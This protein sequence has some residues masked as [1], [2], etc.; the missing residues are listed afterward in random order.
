MDKKEKLF[1]E[2]ENSYE[3]SKSDD[4][5][6]EHKYNGDE[7]VIENSYDDDEVKDDMD[8]LYEVHN[9]DIDRKKE[10]KKKRKLLSI[11]GEIL[12]YV[13]LI[14]VCAIIIPNYVI[15]RTI[16]DGPSMENTLHDGEN[17]LVEKFLYKAKGLERFD[18]VVFYPYGRE[19]TD[20]YVKRV[21]GLPGET[22]QIIGSDI[23][24][25]G[26]LLEENY[27]KDK[28]TNPGIAKKPI[29]LSE[30]EIFVL[31]DNREVSLDSRYEQVGPVPLEYV[32]G[33]VILRIYPFNKFGTID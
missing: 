17:V 21:I 3:N 22:V 12:F 15:Q 5:A 16:V 33:R 1:I 13:V 14:Y 23:Y 9:E 27:G 31:G 28:I 29:T 30:N 7:E 8:L 4:E 25:N 24:I 10:P 20:Y 32:G 11:L 6:M 19:H 2:K 26:E 18:V